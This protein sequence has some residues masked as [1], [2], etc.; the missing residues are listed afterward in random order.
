MTLTERL[1]KSGCEE[2]EKNMSFEIISLEKFLQ[3]NE[4]LPVVQQ[5]SDHKIKILKLARKFAKKVDGYKGD[6][7]FVW[8]LSFDN[9][10]SSGLFE[11]RISQNNLNELSL[12]NTLNNVNLNKVNFPEFKE[13]VSKCNEAINKVLVALVDYH[14]CEVCDCKTFYD[15]EVE[16]NDNIVV[17]LCGDCK[18]THKIIVA[19]KKNGYFKINHE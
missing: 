18:K 4:K 15:A 11:V 6:R 19:E 1:K 17:S 14:H 5:I 12:L 9:G 8:T 13:I 10:L 16:Y 7:N 2:K 3:E